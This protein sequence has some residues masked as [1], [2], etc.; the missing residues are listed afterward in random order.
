MDEL[1]LRALLELISCVIERP[2]F[3]SRERVTALQLVQADL[4]ECL[5]GITSPVNEIDGRKVE[6]FNLMLTSEI[7]VVRTVAERFLAGAENMEE[8]VQFLRTYPTK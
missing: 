6:A 4:L 2:D 5:R 8:F 3:L 7:P 1:I